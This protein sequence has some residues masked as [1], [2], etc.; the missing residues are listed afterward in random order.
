MTEGGECLGFLTA[1]IGFTI[2]LDASDY[3]GEGGLKSPRSCLNRCKGRRRRTL[4]QLQDCVKEFYRGNSPRATLSP[5][6]KF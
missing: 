1:Q 6:G 4:W 3:T 2:L 5:R